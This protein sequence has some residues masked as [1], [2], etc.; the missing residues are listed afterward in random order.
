MACKY[1]RRALLD[2]PSPASC[3]RMFQHPVAKQMPPHKQHKQ[4]VTAMQKPSPTVNPSLY[5]SSTWYD[6]YSLYTVYQG[7]TPSYY[8]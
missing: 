4:E 5:I 2:L 6:V 8:G 3:F 1:I 7:P